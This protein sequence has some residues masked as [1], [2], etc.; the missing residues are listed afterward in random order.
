MCGLIFCGDSKV[1]IP[2]CGSTLACVKWQFPHFQAHTCH[3]CRTT[4][5]IL[6]LC[7]PPNQPGSV[8]SSSIFRKVAISSFHCHTCQLRKTT[9]KK[10]NILN[11]ANRKFPRPRYEDFRLPNPCKGNKACG[12]WC[13]REEMN[14][15][16]HKFAKI[17]RRPNFHEFPCP[18]LQHSP[19]QQHA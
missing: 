17:C 18:S 3:N 14:T 8:F 1:C 15:I 4:T 2:I 6:Y 13:C 12:P 5:S 11:Q 19:W 9:G 10:R 7:T 16:L